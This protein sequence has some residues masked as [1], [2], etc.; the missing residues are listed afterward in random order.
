MHGTYLSVY[1]IIEI[2]EYVGGD[3]ILPLINK[4]GRFGGA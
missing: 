3:V 4:K 2:W 1:M